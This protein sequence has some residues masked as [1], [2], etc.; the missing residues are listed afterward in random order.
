MEKCFRSVIESS[1][2]I[3]L[4]GEFYRTAIKPAMLFV[5][6]VGQYKNNIVD[7]IKYCQ[8]EDD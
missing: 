6:S 7:G 3:R 5:M 4:M 1:I 8:D 2:P